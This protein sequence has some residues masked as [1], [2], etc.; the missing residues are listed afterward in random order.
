MVDRDKQCPFMIALLGK[1]ETGRQLLLTF[2]R[3]WLSGWKNSEIILNYTTNQ[4]HFDEQLLHNFTLDRNIM[5][6]NTTNM[7]ARSVCGLIKADQA[8]LGGYK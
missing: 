1:R 2:L 4:F 5:I 6:H 7:P 3:G 8:L